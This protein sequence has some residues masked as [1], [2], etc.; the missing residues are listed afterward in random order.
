MSGAALAGPMEGE[1]KRMS[2][3]FW[4]LIGLLT[5]LGCATV[6]EQ[7]DTTGA[8]AVLKLP[9]SIRLLEMDARPIESTTHIDAFRMPPGRHVLQLAHLN[10]GS[11]GSA[12]HDGQLAAPFTL[13][14]HA[15]LV[16]VLESKT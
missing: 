9:A 15:G 1:I 4:L 13:D 3:A 2:R 6:P 5:L 11:D 16:Y 14:V 12:A 7:L 10:A 8:Y